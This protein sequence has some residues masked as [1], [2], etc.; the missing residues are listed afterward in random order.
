[1]GIAT[2]YRKSARRLLKVK[3]WQ[4]E[5]QMLQTWY[6]L[7][8][9]F[10]LQSEVDHWPSLPLRWIHFLI[11]FLDSFYGLQPSQCKHQILISIR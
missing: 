5:Y 4:S 3:G 10:M 2:V 7:L 8:R 1:M 9:K 6:S 11:F